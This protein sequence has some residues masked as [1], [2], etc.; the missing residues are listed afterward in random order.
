MFSPG[1]L[2]VNASY[3]QTSEGT[4][5][6]ELGG[7]AAGEEHDQLAVADTSFLGGILRVTVLPSIPRPVAG[8]VYEVLKAASIDGTFETIELQEGLEGIVNHGDT[9]VTFTVAAFVGVSVEEAAIAEL[10]TEVGLFQ[11]YPNPFNPAT[12]L[13]YD[14]PEAADIHLVVFDVLGRVVESLV[15]GHQSLGRHSVVWDAAGVPSG[16][17]FYRLEAGGLVLTKSMFLAK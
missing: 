6:I 14:L 8:N 15:T 7:L 17:Y 4:L 1:I 11:N 5:D 2:T 13:T 3:R 12:T 10:P 16:V 9:E